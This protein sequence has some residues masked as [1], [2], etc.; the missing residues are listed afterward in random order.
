MAAYI[1]LKYLLIVDSIVKL[2]NVTRVTRDTTSK[3]EHQG[4]SSSHSFQE[5]KSESAI[6]YQHRQPFNNF[7]ICHK[8]CDVVVR[9]DEII[10]F[11]PKVTDLD[12][13][14]TNL[15]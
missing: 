11:P 15:D 10:S 6:N 7:I 3:Q 12:P 8:G 1:S 13:I 9:P 4:Q 14:H 2:Q 5:S